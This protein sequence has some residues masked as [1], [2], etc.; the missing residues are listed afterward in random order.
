MLRNT[1][2]LKIG[3]V[4][5]AMPPTMEIGRK[6]RKGSSKSQSLERQVLQ[7]SKVV[8]VSDESRT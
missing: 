6:P 2:N 4:I 7:H 5:R 8:G 3:V 1:S